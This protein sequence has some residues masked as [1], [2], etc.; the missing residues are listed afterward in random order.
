MEGGL[1]TCCHDFDMGF[2]VEFVIYE[3]AEVAYQ[4]Q[5]TNLESPAAGNPQVNRQPE[6]SDTCRVGSTGLECDEFHFVR[7]KVE[8][9]A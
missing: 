7:V 4:R 2:P 3:D 5:S 9:V 6:G 1:C 8:A